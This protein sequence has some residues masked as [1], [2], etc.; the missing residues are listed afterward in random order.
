[1]MGHGH[2][3]RTA[4]RSSLTR[5]M[6]NFDL[7]SGSIG[8]RKLSDACPDNRHINNVRAVCASWSKQVLD[9]SAHGFDKFWI[10]FNAFLK[11]DLNWI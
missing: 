1:M 5:E 6:Y 2:D 11:L 3:N 7:L 10:V 4:N 9:Y 8:H